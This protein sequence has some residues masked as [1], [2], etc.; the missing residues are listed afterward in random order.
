LN[1]D[2]WDKAGHEYAEERDRH[3]GAMRTVTR[4]LTQLN[5]EPGSTADAR[6]ARALP[7]IAR[8]PNR[9]PDHLNSG[10]DLPVNESVRRRYFGEE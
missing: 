8:E 10:P 7:L 1:S 5:F 9:M 2:D 3:F 4:W 6:R